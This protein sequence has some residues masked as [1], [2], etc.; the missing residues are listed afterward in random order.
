MY[1]VRLIAA[2]LALFIAI[3]QASSVQD[4]ALAQEGCVLGAGGY[5]LVVEV[6]IVVFP[7]LINAFFAFNTSLI[8]GG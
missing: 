4:L 5:Y 6:Q 8:I 2:L 1:F 7:V 3:V